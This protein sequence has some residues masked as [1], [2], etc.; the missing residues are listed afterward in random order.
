MQGLSALATFWRW[1]DA[2]KPGAGMAWDI[3]T[4]RLDPASPTRCVGF[5]EHRERT[6]SE[7]PPIVTVS[8]EPLS[9][10][11]GFHAVARPGVLLIAHN[12]KYEAQ[13]LI[14]RGID[15]GQFVWW[16]TMLAEWVLVANNTRGLGLNLDDTAQRYGCAPKDPWVDEMIKAGRVMEVP[17]DR[18][19][20]RNRKDVADC[21]TVYEAQLARMTEAQ[22]RLTI[23]RSMQMLELARI[24]LEGKQLDPA[25][26][27]AHVE[28]NA[29]QIAEHEAALRDVTR[30]ANPRSVNEMA[31]LLYGLWPADTPEDDKYQWDPACQCREPLRRHKGV[32]RCGKCKVPAVRGAPLVEPLGFR[33][34]VDRKGNKMRTAALGSK[35]WP[36]GRPQLSVDAMTALAKSARTPRQ[37]LWAKHHLALMDLY[38]ERDKNLRYFAAVCEKAGGVVYAELMQGV[39]ATHRL[40]C[41]GKPIPGV[42]YSCQLQ[43][44]PQHLKGVF[45]CKR[46]DHVTGEVDQSQA[47]FRGAGFLS[48]C[49]Q[50]LADIAN[51]EFDAHIQS[52]QVL[53]DGARDDAAYRALFAQYKAD[54]K[55]VKAL[56][57]AA[58]AH[59]FKPLFGGSSGTDRERAYYKWFGEHYHGITAAQ[60]AWDDEV[61]WTGKYVSPTGMVF[62]WPVGWEEGYNGDLRMVNADTKRSLYSIVRNLPIQYFATGEM[63]TVSFLCLV[64]ECRRLGIRWYPVMLVHDSAEGELHRDDIE[65]WHETCGN[66]YGPLTWAFLHAVY[67]IDYNVELAAE[68]SHGTHFGEGSDRAHHYTHKGTSHMKFSEGGE[69]RQRT[70]VSAGNH[71]MVCNQVVDMGMQKGSAQYPAPKRKVYIRFEVPG[72][73]VTY[74]RGDEELEGPLVIGTTLTASMNEKAALRKLIESGMGKRFKAGEAGN[75]DVASILGKAFLGNV[76][77]T[78]KGDQTYANI[79]TLAPLPKGMPSPKA[80]RP[81]LAYSPEDGE[82]AVFQQ[83]APWLQKQIRERILPGEPGDVPRNDGDGAPDLGQE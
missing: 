71:L 15:P 50:C 51:P 24:E 11:R 76:V 1:R 74:K 61:A 31:P 54:P 83:L 65:A 66:S 53:R 10:C 34:P 42:D 37:K 80:E 57:S 60:A 49:P 5:E 13:A 35:S 21:R 36:G 78:Q 40:T 30:G 27:A 2:I 69:K 44:V 75:F 33:E 6:V 45:T 12:A 63:A 28:R 43:N 72:E 20:E 29:R 73:R 70:N 23:V 64:Y 48:Q 16:D 82:N 79:Q 38:A 25:R 22:V 58:K 39:A 9:E 55:A 77:E 81:L 47:E 7:W 14:T 4:E 19:M 68:S 41:R 17:L 26:V 52:G 32:R 3:E 56:R 18:L 8:D 59:T 67:G 46:A 62:Q